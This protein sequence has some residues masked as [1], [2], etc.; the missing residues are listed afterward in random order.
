[1]EITEAI[2]DEH[3]L[4]SLL[5]KREKLF[6]ELKRLNYELHRLN[7]AI[8]IYQPKNNGS[9]T[10]KKLNAEQLDKGEYSLS[11]SA[12][13]QLHY[14]LKH[15]G[16]ATLVDITNYIYELDNS[17]H[18]S[19]LRKRLTDVASLEYRKNRINGYKSEG[20]FVYSLKGE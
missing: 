3:I 10:V 20:R 14:A 13:Q 19:K 16:S 6:D 15:L 9:Y 2:T 17:M 4:S 1:M 7:V 12:L 11:F 5:I 18:I 8:D